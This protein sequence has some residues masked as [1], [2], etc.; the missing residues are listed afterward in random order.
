MGLEARMR[1]QSAL[2]PPQSRHR[3]KDRDSR[4]I[5]HLGL[6]RGQRVAFPLGN[7]DTER[8]PSTFCGSQSLCPQGTLY[9]AVVDTVST[10]QKVSVCDPSTVVAQH[11]FHSEENLQGTLFLLP[12]RP[13]SISY[14]FIGGS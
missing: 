14:C 12:A 5:V 7:G 6:L 3:S 11:S 1:A 4:P 2:G 8:E 9:A 10:R 13:I